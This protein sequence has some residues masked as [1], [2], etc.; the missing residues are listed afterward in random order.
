[1]KIV[2][3]HS[4][5]DSSYGVLEDGIPIVHN[6]LERFNRRKNSVED[7]IK[8][9]LK[10]EVNLNDIKYMAIHRTAGMVKNKYMDSFNKCEELI[11]KNDGE[12]FIVGH[13]QSHAANAFFTSNFEEALIDCRWFGP[14]SR[15]SI[16]RFSIVHPNFLDHL[17]A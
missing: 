14:P 5:H 7:S 6:E 12:L 10:N 9:F 17:N 16:R 4:G 8:F 11:N 13:H 3:F 15:P 1:M 2:G